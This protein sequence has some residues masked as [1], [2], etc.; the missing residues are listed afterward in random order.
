M[1]I[2]A[3]GIRSI[4]LWISIFIYELITNLYNIFERLCK[5]RILNSE[6]IDTLAQRIG[7]LLGIVMLFIVSFSIIQMIL[8]PDKLTDK[9]KGIGNITKKIILVIVMLGTSTAAFNV[10]Y[11]VQSTIIDSHIISKFMLPNYD[12]NIE[13]FGGILSS[14]LFLSFFKPYEQYESK[15]N[16]DMINLKMDIRNYNDF[17][18]ATNIVNKGLEQFA[19]WTWGT[20]EIDFNWLLCPLL[21]IGA[22]Y[23]LFSYC[24]TVGTRALQ[25]AFLEI[26]SPAAII[27]YLSPKKD[28]MFE[29]WWK[30]YFATYLDV[31]IRIMIINLAV[32]LI[33]VLLDSDMSQTFWQSVGGENSS[34]AVWVKIFMMLAILTFAKKAPDLL[35]DLFPA[36]ASKLGLG[37]STP[38][39]LFSNMLGGNLV[40]GGLTGAAGFGIGAAVGGIGNIG[41][42]LF[43]KDKDGNPLKWRD[44]L[45]GAKSGLLGGAWS[46]AKAGAGAKGIWKAFGASNKAAGE[47][48][49][50]IAEWRANG[51]VSG[52]TRWKTGMEQ[53][54]G[55]NTE[56]DRLDLAKADIEAENA[57]YNQ[58]S[59]YFDAAK[60]RAEKKILEGKL[61]G[62]SVNAAD[63]LDASRRMEILKAQAG[64]LNKSDARFQT[65]NA[66]T[67]VLE[68]DQSKY[69]AEM[70]RIL[71]DIDTQQARYNTAMKMATEDYF[72]HANAD[73]NFDAVINQNMEMAQAVL[74][75]NRNYNSLAGL[76]VSDFNTFDKANNA[77]KT[78]VKDNTKKLSENKNK[79][80][81]ARADAKYNPKSGK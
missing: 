17:S 28:T 1:D 59:G 11:S 44:K 39:Q 22:L 66:T 2:I 60:S 77:V 68:F 29:K 53:K 42:S 72:A 56:A 32:F 69:D 6:I 63:V 73:S 74:D 67:G 45:A 37:V 15:Y 30:V 19:F 20:F 26:I 78:A 52:W 5:A 43:A 13:N 79:G 51:G 76:N 21:G 75:N 58:F 35:K 25:L 55:L 31:F 33:A 65:K 80:R 14:E 46:G 70:N 12:S 64:N 61:A 38:K 36:G 18:I 40:K 71:K 7:M 50:R 62:K 49:R 9:E 47:Q 57:V 23:F 81:T 27:S 16:Q 4:F 8:E 10:L 54:F 34:G 24:I 41:R 3:K 48:S